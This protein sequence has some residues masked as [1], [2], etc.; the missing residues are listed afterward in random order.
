MKST[1]SNSV[2]QIF[3]NKKNI[4][5]LVLTTMIVGSLLV[6]KLFDTQ[7]YEIILPKKIIGEKYI[8]P[9]SEFEP[10]FSIVKGEKLREAWHANQESYLGVCEKYNISIE[11]CEVIRKALQNQD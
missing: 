7:N 9:L 10:A 5:W 4:F 11:R 1:N 8:N 3:L 2:F 6:L